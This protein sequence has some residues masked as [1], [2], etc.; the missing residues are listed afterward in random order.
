MMLPQYSSK[1]VDVFERLSAGAFRRLVFG[2]EL[3]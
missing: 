1:P 3:E 2:A